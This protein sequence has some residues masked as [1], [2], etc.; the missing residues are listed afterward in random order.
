MVGWFRTL[1]SRDESAGALGRHGVLFA[2]LVLLLVAL[3]VAESLAGATPS[4]RL[5]LS[6]VLIAAIYV[7]SRQRWVFLAAAAV[8]TAAIVTPAVAIFLDSAAL[9]L[10]GDALG[11]ALLGFTTLVMTASL[12]QTARVSRDTIIGG[13]CVYLLIGLCFAMTFILIAEV[14]PAAFAAESGPIIV[15][16]RAPQSDSPKLLYFSFVTLTTLGYG[17]I[18]PASELTQML[19]DSEALIGQLYLT[20]FLARLVAL[21]VRESTSA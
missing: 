18:A 7:N 19:A 11:L 8:G 3:P 12:I 14:D 21:F 4:F 10:A 9:T 15:D 2:S 13:I 6:L 17:D 1:A 20:I 5:L 16:S